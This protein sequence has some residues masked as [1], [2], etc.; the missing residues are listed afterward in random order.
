MPGAVTLPTI[1][2]IYGGNR[3]PKAYAVSWFY[4]IDNDR[5]HTLKLVRRQTQRNL[6]RLGAPL[7]RKVTELPKAK[8]A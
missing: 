1:C 8:E 3:G 6:S 2:A 5:L 4:S 7:V